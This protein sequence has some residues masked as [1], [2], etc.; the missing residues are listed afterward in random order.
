MARCGRGSLLLIVSVGCVSPQSDESVTATGTTASEPTADTAVEAIHPSGMVLPA[1]IVALPNLDD[2]DLDG[3]T[4]F[5]DEEVVGDNDIFLYEL[6]PS[7][8]G[9]EAGVSHVELQL[10][11]DDPSQLRLS[12]ADGTPI[13]V[14]GEP[15]VVGIE[16]PIALRF[17]A[18]AYLREAQ[19]QVTEV[20]HE[21]DPTTWLVPVGSPP[22]VFNHHL[23]TAE[24]V[25]G[26]FMGGPW[27]NQ[28]FVA[29]FEDVIGDEFTRL[30]GWVYDW[31]VWVQDEVEFSSVVHPSGQHLDVVMDSTRDR[32]LDDFPE[33]LFTL[34]DHRIATWGKPFRSTSQDSFGNVEVSPPVV[35]GE[36]AYPFGRMYY[37]AKDDYNGYGPDR[38]FR[39]GADSMHVQD[40]FWV[41][42]SWLCVGHVD[43]V[44]AF[45][46]DASSAKGFKL[47]FSDVEAAWALLEDM[48]PHQVIPHYADHGFTTVAALLEDD[49]LVDYNEEVRVDHLE[50]MKEK[51]MEE[52]GLTESDI[53]A[54]PSLF[55]VTAGCGGTGAS[56][57]PG[58]ANLVV[59][60]LEGEPTRVFLADPFMRGPS[61]E[62]ADDPFIEEVTAL[63]PSDLELHFVD[64]WDNYHMMLGEV[65][66][67]T[68]V[69]RTPWGDWLSPPDA[70]VVA[71][72]GLEVLP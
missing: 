26:M 40:P 34:P 28:D 49:D 33:N 68:N 38:L 30:T 11:A 62:Q 64:D 27:G 37:G 65:H 66:C 57:I 55:E 72:T 67:G 24:Q 56:L 6:L 50:P 44:M 29:A 63:L 18:G 15:L 46:P 9:A 71:D 1:H 3:L 69:L 60:E 8:N 12:L 39:E 58:M 16:G 36:Q 4:D 54:L 47:V 53:I 25:Y 21:G 45:V 32:G 52:L 20:L 5:D 42:T 7:A 41:D 70:S 19:L 59:V 61:D 14:L 48:D 22:L 35:V 13:P 43:E 51:M 17:E 23:Q 2:D 31:D 10:L